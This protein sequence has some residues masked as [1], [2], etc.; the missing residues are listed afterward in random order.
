[1]NVTYQEQECS[2]KSSNAYSTRDPCKICVKSN[3]LCINHAPF[4]KDPGHVTASLVWSLSDKYTQVILKLLESLLP[5]TFSSTF[6]LLL[7][8]G[9][10]Y[11]A[12][13][14]SDMCLQL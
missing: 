14:A 2:L 4:I 5:S 1:M 10:T 9:T 11:F 8:S 6:Y 12:I 7:F 3:I 13:S